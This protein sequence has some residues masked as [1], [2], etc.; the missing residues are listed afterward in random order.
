MSDR[1]EELKKEY[2]DLTQKL[3]E[4]EFLDS[5]DEL[6]EASKRL[7]ELEK[8][9][10]T[11]E[12]HDARAKRRTEAETIL[13]DEDADP[14]FKKLAE[15][16]IERI[17]QEE[18]KE[19]KA[20]QEK[21]ALI[22]EIRPGTGGDEAALFAADLARMYLR[23]AEN[24]GW[25]AVAV[26][27]SLTELGGLKSLTLSIEGPGAFSL[28][29]HEAGVHRVQRV[30]E[31][32]KSGRIHT[33]TATVAVLQK[34]APKAFRV[35]AKDLRVDT[36]RAGGPG[37]QLVNRR[38]SAVRITH[39]PSGIMVTSQAARTQS[40]NREQAMEILLAKLAEIHRKEEA[41][42]KGDA[43]KAQIGTGERSEKIR[44]YNFPQDR[45][46]DHRV[47]KSW[48]NLSSI[49]DGNIGDIVAILQEQ[50]S[51]HMAE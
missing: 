4:G 45:V 29:Q 44:T 14:E 9:L 1:R 28:L 50:K 37:G 16:E 21:Q 51:K 2:D 5:Q 41:A 13:A 42:K 3:A 33:S 31:T 20:A 43:R 11:L 23:F 22:M 39:L 12:A 19:A 7:G 40:A 38:E 26:D 36:M 15:E 48:H 34:I 10:E 24:K 18:E 27:E 47:N 46:T 17:A 8:E 35:P 25:K 32:E 6:A 30:P 49:L